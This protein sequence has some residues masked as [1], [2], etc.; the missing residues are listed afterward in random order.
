M[1]NGPDTFCI[2]ASGLTGDAGD[3][4][5]GQSGTHFVAVG[6][7]QGDQISDLIMGLRLF[8]GIGEWIELTFTTE[9]DSGVI[10][11]DSTGI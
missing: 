6:P 11:P 4:G 10:N 8:T 9:A 7:I 1:P 5:P 3:I 2:L